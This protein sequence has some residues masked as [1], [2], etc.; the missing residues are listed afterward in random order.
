MTIFSCVHLTAAMSTRTIPA[1]SS[2]KSR[3]PNISQPIY[4]TS[5]KGIPFTEQFKTTGHVTT[6]E[7]VYSL[8]ANADY[9]VRQVLKPD[10]A[11]VPAGVPLSEALS[12]KGLGGNRDSAASGG[13]GG[14]VAANRLSETAFFTPRPGDGLSYLGVAADTHSAYSTS[15]GHRACTK[16]RSATSAQD[17]LTETPSGLTHRSHTNAAA[18]GGAHQKVLG[19][20]EM[21][22]NGYM[23]PSLIRRDPTPSS[24]DNVTHHRLALLQETPSDPPPQILD[25]ESSIPEG[26]Y[27]LLHTPPPIDRSNKPLQMPT[28]PPAVD[29]ALKP[30][31]RVETE[32]SDSSEGSPPQR[33]WSTHCPP[34]TKLP[35]GSSNEDITREENEYQFNLSEIPRVT[36]RSTHY[37]QVDFNPDT[38]RP[39]PLP[40]KTFHSSG[41]STPTSVVP[42]PR[43]VTYTDV[44][45][46]ATNQL[47]DRLNRQV[48]VREAE[49]KALSEKH[50]VNVDHSGTIDDETDPD[51][52]T[53]MRVRSYK[54]DTTCTC[55]SL[56]CVYVCVCVCVE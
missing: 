32:L 34:S 31:R 43:R 15:S 22:S 26:S 16:T 1:A 33:R 13:S 7:S 21:L 51:Y 4:A 38:R 12:S 19:G 27:G 14:D 40:R 45:I 2:T 3:E 25:Q 9:D 53:H 18:Y 10:S 50:Y 46:Q 49:R 11:D 24:G 6:T 41:G 37:T 17:L 54:S 44:D 47:A 36:L 28:P 42:K 20:A 35:V 56:H 55:I 23:K 48:T 5:T 39:I 52:Y 29:R 8:A 30:G